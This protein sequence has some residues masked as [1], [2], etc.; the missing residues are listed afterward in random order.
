MRV[1]SVKA[2]ET[3]LACVKSYP[4]EVSHMDQLGFLTIS[5]GEGAAMTIPPSELMIVGTKLMILH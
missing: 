1:T 2:K 5:P 4:V 3:T